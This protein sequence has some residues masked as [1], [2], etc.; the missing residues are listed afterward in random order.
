MTR[1]FE[2]RYSIIHNIGNHL[3]GLPWYKPCQKEAPGQ[4]IEET[5][6]LPNGEV[7]AAFRLLSELA[8]I[9]ASV[10]DD[11]HGYCNQWA[12]SRIFGKSLEL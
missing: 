10:G 4:T 12:M 8:V 9:M 1:R 6:F 5:V 2:R 11:S 3:V 7:V